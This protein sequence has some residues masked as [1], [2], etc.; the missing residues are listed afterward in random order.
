MDV[1]QQLAYNSARWTFGPLLSFL[2]R[3]KCEGHDNIPAE[4]G[5][6]V[7][8]NHRNPFLDPFAMAVKIT[9]PINFMAASVFFRL[10]V[11]GRVYHAWGAVPLEI[12]GGEKSRKC[13]DDAV[14]LLEEGELVGMFPEGVHTIANVRKTHKV[15][16]FKTG[17]ARLALLARVPIVPVALIG[18]GERTL[19]S[20]PPSIVKPFFDHPDYED[21][22]EIRY[23][24]RLLIRIGRP[25]DISGFYGDKITGRLTSDISGRVRRV[26]MK[27]YNGEDLDRLM[28]GEE[29][30]DLAADDV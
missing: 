9:R 15:R 18:R 6:L 26:I 20:F 5:A 23:Y 25:L 10:P 16:S 24:K 19:A 11:V 4:G 3:L 27:L 7:T 14:A 13:L 12:S 1:Y 2:I 22:A 29:P 28:T 21:G 30:F 8:A 17:F